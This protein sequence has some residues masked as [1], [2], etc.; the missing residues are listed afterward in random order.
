MNLTRIMKLFSLSSFL[1]TLFLS[2]TNAFFQPTMKF[3]ASLGNKHNTSPTSLHAA[4]T[5]RCFDLHISVD[6]MLS[7]VLDSSN[8]KLRSEV[9]RALGSSSSV[10]VGEVSVVR[11]SFDSR[12]KVRQERGGPVWNVVADV[13]VEGKVREKRGRVEKR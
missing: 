9:V 13:E 1:V 2:S 7:G 12:R 8:S 10:V 6:D 3:P 11:Y 4:S 5:Y